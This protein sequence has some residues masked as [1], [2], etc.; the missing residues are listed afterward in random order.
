MQNIY[1]HEMKTCT[2]NR[3]LHAVY[4][5]LQWNHANNTY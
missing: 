1:K 4:I 3:L 5:H 2:C